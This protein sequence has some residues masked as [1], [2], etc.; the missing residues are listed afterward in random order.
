MAITKKIRDN[1]CWWGCGQKGTLVHCWW[2]GKLVQSLWKLMWRCL[3]ILKTELPCDPTIPL[4]GIYLKEMKSLFRKHIC[5]HMFTVA[6][7]TIFKTWKKSKYPHMDKWIKKMRNTYIYTHTHTH[8][9]THVWIHT[10]WN[11]LQPLKKTQ[12]KICQL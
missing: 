12:R 7:F 3:K 1:K 4:L 6:L 9:H 5:T 11:I 2:G 8:T 10:Q